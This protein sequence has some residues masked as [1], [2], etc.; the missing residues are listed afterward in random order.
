MHLSTRE[1][2]QNSNPSLSDSRALIFFCQFWPHVM[3]V[4]KSLEKIVIDHEE[5]PRQEEEESESKKHLK[6]KR[7]SKGKS[8]EE[9]LMILSQETRRM[10]VPLIRN[11]RGM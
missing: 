10:L 7:L 9:W 3:R 6:A 8:E 5:L 1:Q 2:S 11:G 4:E